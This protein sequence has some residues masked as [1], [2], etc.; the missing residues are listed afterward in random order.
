MWS[1]SR[2]RRWRRW[3]NMS[4]SDVVKN[5]SAHF[6]GKFHGSK[7]HGLWSTVL[8]NLCTILGD[9]C[10]IIVSLLRSWK[11]DVCEFIFKVP[12]NDCKSGLDCKIGSMM[13]SNPQSNPLFWNGF[14]IQVQS[15]KKECNPD[16]AILQSQSWWCL[17]RE[18]WGGI[19][20][21]QRRILS[22]NKRVL[23]KTRRGLATEMDLGGH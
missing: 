7:C 18:N 5:A 19:G 9:G 16:F 22:K 23:G 8:R 10:Y 12:G 14:Q 15:T 20:E 21:P 1:T 4:R 17:V 11:Y 3:A 2:G 6:R 13:Q